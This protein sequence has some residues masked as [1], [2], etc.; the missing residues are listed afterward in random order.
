MRVMRVLLAAMACSMALGSPR[1]DGRP[2]TRPASAPATRPLAAAVHGLGWIIFGAKT[3]KGDWDLFLMRPDGSDLRNVTNTPDVNEGLARFSPDG[4]RMLYRRIGRGERFDNNRHGMQGEL[5]IANSDGTSPQAMGKNGQYT[6]AS[7]SPDGKSI[8]CLG[9]GGIT[10]V[11]LD[12]QRVTSSLSRRGFFQQ[13]IWS[14]DGKWLVGVSNGFDTEWSVARMRISDGAVNPISRGNSCTPDWFGDSARVIHS[15]R[16][17]QWTQLWMADADG[18]RPGLIYA[19]EGRHVYG[20]CVSPDGQYV[21]LTGNNQEDGDPGNSGAP[22]G[23]MRLGDAPIIG[24]PSPALP[25]QYPNANRG[26]VLPL[27]AGWEPHW[28]SADVARSH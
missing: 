18:K 28:T 10:F 12:S 17:G 16:P 26:P 27:P 7:W 9:L 24:G 25:K 20:G 6:W 1:A 15:H 8:A 19:E 11:D 2:A 4:K 14:P 22:M 3:P 5:F 23:L 13:M 21:L